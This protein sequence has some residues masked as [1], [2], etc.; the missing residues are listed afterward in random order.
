MLVKKR[1]GQISEDG[2]NCL[3]SSS[4]NNDDWLYPR[5]AW[6]LTA[7][8][9]GA[10]HTAIQIWVRSLRL[11]QPMERNAEVCSHAP[12]GW[13]L[14]G[15]DAKALEL[16]LPRWIPGHLGRGGVRPLW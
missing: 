14:V 10:V 16:T 12:D 6:L 1:L 7:A 15:V 9:L 8:L 13:D 11:T 2:S 3:A 5:R 4:Y